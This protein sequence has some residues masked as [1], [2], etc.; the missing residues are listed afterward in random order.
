MLPT[1]IRDTGYLPSPDALTGPETGVVL[2]QGDSLVLY[3]YISDTCV[4]QP[5][6]SRPR[7]LWYMQAVHGKIEA[8]K[9]SYILI[10]QHRGCTRRML[11]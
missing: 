8:K 7:I 2:L 11:H 6:V 5:A 10:L 1:P 9:H 4:A 3:I